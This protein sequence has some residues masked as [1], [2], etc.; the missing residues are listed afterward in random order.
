MRVLYTGDILSGDKIG[1]ATKVL[2]TD[3]HHGN[4]TLVIYCG[5]FITLTQVAAWVPDMFCNFNIVKNCKMANNSRTT[6]TNKNKQI[7]GILRTFKNLKNL[8]T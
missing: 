8:K 6:Y 4:L 2:A 7:F 5:I 3:H 1:M